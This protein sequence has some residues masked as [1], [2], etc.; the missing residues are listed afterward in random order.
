MSEP[1]RTITWTSPSGVT[2]ELPIETGDESPAIEA[3]GLLRQALTFAEALARHV[4]AGSPEATPEQA[5]ARLAIC[6]GCVYFD[7]EAAR[8]KACG[9]RMEVKVT[10]ADASC[11]LDPPKWGPVTAD[12]L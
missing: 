4:A 11:P 6:R 3:P 2:R 5:E 12:A 1:R 10:W 8:C 9:C 7:P